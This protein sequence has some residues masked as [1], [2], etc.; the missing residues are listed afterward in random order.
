MDNSSMLNY[1]GLDYKLHYPGRKLSPSQ[2]QK[3][4][5]ILNGNFITMFMASLTPVK[6][7][8]I[9]PTAASSQNGAALAL[10]KTLRDE[11]RAV[12]QQKGKRNGLFFHILHRQCYREQ[13][14]L[15]A[16]N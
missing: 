4:T 9:F 1:I 2:D 13:V 16:Q 12:L 8:A 5:P 7:T 10:S 15:R 6:A 3:G 14:M 11:S